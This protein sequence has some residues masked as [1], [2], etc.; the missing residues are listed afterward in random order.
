MIRLAKRLEQLPPYPFAQLDA[1][2]QRAQARGLDTVSMGI[3]DP[4]RDPPQWIRELLCEEVM[5][6]GNHRYP[7]YKGHPRLLDSAIRYMARRFG[8]TGLTLDNV[9]TTIGSKEGLAN[10][11]TA[12]I[13][14]EDYFISPDPMYPVFPTLAK[15]QGA[16]PITVPVHPG[17]NFMPD[18]R[19][20][21][22][23]HQVHSSRVMYVNYPHNPTGQVATREYLQELVDFA[24]E[25]SLIVVSDA[26]YAEVFYDEENR[27]ASLL[28]FDGALDC[29]IEFHSFSK[30][31]DMTGWRCGFAMGCPALINGLLAVKSNVDSGCFNAIQLAMARVLDDERCDPFLAENRAHYHKRLDKVCTALTEMGITY[32]RPGASIFIWCDLPEGERSSFDWCS[33]LLDAS[34]LVVSPGAA[35]GEY[36]EGFFRISLSTPDEHIDRALEKLRRFVSG[37]AR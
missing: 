3:G 30:S 22:S 13:N 20:E 26:A 5:R 11:V 35:Y 16:Q 32:Y 27:P 7:S 14:P 18:L 6:S 37:T 1:A 19:R 8:V 4:D 15:L 24:V 10:L 17:T 31:F 34:G 9:M 29:V 33:R 21:L 25:N 28:E 2:R 36:G 12:V 23:E